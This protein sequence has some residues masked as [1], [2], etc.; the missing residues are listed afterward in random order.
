[1]RTVHYSHM[2]RHIFPPGKYV[3][4]PHTFLLNRNVFYGAVLSWLPTTVRLTQFWIPGIGV[5][6]SNCLHHCGP[7]ACL[8]EMALINNACWSAQFT[9]VVPFPRQVV[10]GCVRKPA[11]PEPA[12]TMQHSSMV[13]AP[14]SCPG[15][16]ASL[17]SMVDCNSSRKL[18]LARVLFY[19]STRTETRTNALYLCYKS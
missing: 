7:W 9:T 2:K 11:K 12:N 4:S 6:M 15:F 1:M 10:L 17:H 3:P 18:L 13:S 5:S 14:A 8:W 19:H 16:L